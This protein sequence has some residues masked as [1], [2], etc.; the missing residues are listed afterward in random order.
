KTQGSCKDTNEC[1]A[2]AQCEDVDQGLQS[3]VA[4]VT[5]AAAFGDESSGAQVFA[6]TG[7]CVEISAT[8]CSGSAQCKPGEYCA[9]GTCRRDQGA[10]ATDADCTAGSCTKQLLITATAA[11]S[12]G[13]GLPDPLDNCPQVPNPSQADADGDGVGDACDVYL[14]EPDAI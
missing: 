10:C 12:D 6:S 13:D 4:P 3:I 8:S 1:A 2:P 9:G 11:D 14:P 7:T 5:S